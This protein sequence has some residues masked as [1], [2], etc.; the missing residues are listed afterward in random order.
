[1]KC[2]RVVPV[3]FGFSLDLC[4]VCVPGVSSPSRKESIG[5][6]LCKKGRSKVLGFFLVNQHEEEDALRRRRSK[7]KHLEDNRGVVVHTKEEVRSLNFWMREKNRDGLFR[8]KKERKKK[9]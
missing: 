3:V 4:V 7:K 6:H 5:N 1:M 8:G 9:K 2:F